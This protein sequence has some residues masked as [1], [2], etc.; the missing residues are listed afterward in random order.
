V[1]EAERRLVGPLEVI[2]EQEEARG[3]GE[4]EEAAGD[5]VEEAESFFG[6]RE[7]RAFREGTDTT[8]ELRGEAGELGAR[9][10]GD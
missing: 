1:E 6:G 9:V 4:V 10:A 7:L 2:D 5:A 8:F 3:F